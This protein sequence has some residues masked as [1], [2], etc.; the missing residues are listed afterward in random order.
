MIYLETNIAPETL[1]IH[2]FTFSEGQ[3]RAV[4]FGVMCIKGCFVIAEPTQ[5]L[6]KSGI[7]LG[8]TSDVL[9]QIIHLW[10][11][12]QATLTSPYIFAVTQGDVRTHQM[13]FV[14]DM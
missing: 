6:S 12:R 13:I 4:S 1:G 3:V 14:Q 5:N 10:I 2:E 7:G 8:L 11:T 9:Y